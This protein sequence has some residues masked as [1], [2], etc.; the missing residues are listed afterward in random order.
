M[1]SPARGQQLEPE[2]NRREPLDLARRALQWAR[3]DP[4]VLANS[5]AV[6]GL[7]GEDID[8]A[9]RLIDRS[10]ALNPSFARGWGWSAALRN[11][12][13]QRDL[14]IEH[15]N[16]SVR[17]SPRDRLGVLELSFGAAHFFKRHIRCGGGNP[18]CSPARGSG[19]RVDLS[20]SRRMLRPY[21]AA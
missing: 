14:S 3:N 17:L 13:G 2:P 10:L 19:L 5:A 9:I 6:L 4:E 11:V 8:V 7:L 1:S 21:G 18:T 15:F 16:K 12:V 20:F